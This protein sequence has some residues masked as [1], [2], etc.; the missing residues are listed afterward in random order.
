[1][2]CNGCNVLKNN[3]TMD[4]NIRGY[5]QVTFVHDVNAAVALVRVENIG[6]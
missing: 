1:M 5:L 6:A 4:A 2:S 3:K